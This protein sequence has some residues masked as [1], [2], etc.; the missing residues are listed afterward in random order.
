MWAVGSRSSGSDRICPRSNLSHGLRIGWF[1]EEGRAGRRCST[2]ESHPGFPVASSGRGLALEHAR[3]TRNPPMWVVRVCEGCGGAHSEGGG[4]AAARFIGVRVGARYRLDLGCYGSRA[5]MQSMAQRLGALA[6]LWR[7]RTWLATASWPGGTPAS[8]AS[9]GRG[10][11][12][13]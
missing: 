9:R 7:S 2:G 5:H 3:G 12:A 8:G 4:S 1:R 11:T 6:R 13:A 10:S